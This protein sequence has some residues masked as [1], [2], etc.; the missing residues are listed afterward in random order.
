MK[1]KYIIITGGAG[2]IGSNLIELFLKKTNYTLIS[3]DDYSSGN[4]KNHIIS[5]RI[6][7]FKGSTTNIFKI[8][9]KYKNSIE[10]LFHFGEFSRIFQ[11]FKMFNQ[12][13]QSNSIGSQTVFK[14]CLQ[15]KIRLIYS[16]TS[17]YW[18]SWKRS[19][20]ITLCIQK[21]KI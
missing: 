1:K 18:K 8:L 21:Q 15:N 12:C 9:N 5:P 10:S 2:F 17:E 13:Y 7:Y 11:S 19:K 4:K 20:L 6:K 14:F 3:I 16:A